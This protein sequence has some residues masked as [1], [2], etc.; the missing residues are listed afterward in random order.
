MARDCREAI[1]ELV[2]DAATRVHSTFGPGVLESVYE[3]VLVMEL[4]NKG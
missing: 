2:L 1:I 4:A 3:R